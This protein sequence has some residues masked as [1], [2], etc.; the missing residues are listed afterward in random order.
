MRNYKI[1]QYDRKK[2]IYKMNA[3]INEHMVQI[4]T[5]ITFCIH[6][7]FFSSLHEK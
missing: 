3:L 6:F 2:K 4:V 7:F 5:L 1:H